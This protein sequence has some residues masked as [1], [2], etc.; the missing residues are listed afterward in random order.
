[1][2]VHYRIYEKLL[3]VTY[4]ENTSFRISRKYAYATKTSLTFKELLQSL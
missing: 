2:T 1:M 3:S 4:R